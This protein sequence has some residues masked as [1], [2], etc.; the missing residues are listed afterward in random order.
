M[1]EEHQWANQHGRRLRFFVPTNEAMN[2][3]FGAAKDLNP[4][5]KLY[6]LAL[7]ADIDLMWRGRGAKP[8]SFGF[9]F[10]RNINTALE[11]HGEWARTLDSPSNTVS[12][13]GATS[14]QRANFTSYLFGLRYL[15]PGEFT[16]IGE[17]YRNGAGYAASD[18]DDYYQFLDGA[19][20]TSAA[21]GLRNKAQA[22][23]QSGYVKSNPGRD[24]LYLKASVSEPFNL[25]Y[26]SAALTAIT[27]LHDGSFQITP[28]TSYAGFSNVEVRARLIVLGGQR[29]QSLAQL[30]GD[31]AV[32][33]R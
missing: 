31:E 13:M 16:W 32:N 20:A 10:S 3:D 22:V 7:D 4:A 2:A 19:L 12:A 6:L 21:P 29:P 18:L 5:A 1:D 33:C 24:Y 23:A 15:T 11:V 25:V 26:G 28:E 14:K 30:W 8:Q 27:N 9:D 17:Y